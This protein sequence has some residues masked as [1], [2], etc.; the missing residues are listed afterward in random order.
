MGPKM[1]IQFFP[2]MY[3]VLEA[4]SQSGKARTLVGDQGRHGVWVKAGLQT[5]FH[6]LGK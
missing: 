4:M 5:W 6:G 3:K 2:S 1:W